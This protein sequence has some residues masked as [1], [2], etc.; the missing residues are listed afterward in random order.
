MKLL[1]GALL[2]AARADVYMQYPP[3]SNNRLAEGGGNRNNNNRLMDTQNNAKGGYGYGGNANNP[4]DP[5]NYMAGS[6]MSMGWTSQHSCGSENAE[7]Q[8]VVQYMCSPTT[9]ATTPEGLPGAGVNTGTGEGPIRDGTNGNTPD[10]NNP[11]ATRGLHEPTSFYQAC[12]NRERNKGLYTADQ[13]LNGNDARRTRQNP[14]GARS[15]LECPEERDYYPYW[16]PTPWKDAMILTNNLALCQWYKDNSQNVKAR[17]YCANPTGNGDVP[18]NPTG[19][20]AAQG[21]WTEVPAFGL[22]P[23]ECV[24]APFQRD[25]HLG[26]G[27]TGNE[28]MANLT[29]PFNAGGNGIDDAQSCVYRLRYNITTADTRVCEDPT[30][31]TKAACEAA[32]KIWSAMYLDSSFN[33]K[34]LDDTPPLPPGNPRVNLGGTL[35]NGGGTD[36]LLEL[37]INTN[38]YGRTFQDRTHVFSIQSRPEALPDN[39]NIVNLNVKG[40]RGNIVQTYPATEYDYH[41]VDLVVGASDYVHIQ[42]TGNDN[43]NNNG[44]NNGEGTNNED[45]HNIVQIADSGMDVPLPASQASMFDVQ[46]EWN[47]EPTTDANFGGPR[48]Q[49]ALT[50][51]FALSK[52]TGCDAGNQNNDQARDNCEKLN[53]A[54]ATVDLGLIKFKPG[55]FTYMSSRNNNFSNRAQKAHLKVLAAPTAP[56]EAPVN[57]QAVP[58]LSENKDVA[59]MQLTWAEPGARSAFV[60]TDGREY[61]N[62]GQA[63]SKPAAYRVQYTIDGGATWAP[64]ENCQTTQTSCTVDFLPPGTPVGFRVHSGNEAGWGEPSEVVLAKT[65]DS[66]TSLSCQQQLL[67]QMNGSYLSPGSVVAIVLGVIAALFALAFLVFMVRRRQPPPP[68]PPGMMK[69]MAP[70]GGGYA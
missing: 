56:V 53:S 11:S 3:G 41:P 30:L 15:G 1:L 59:R 68:P 7:C 22:A 21:T 43:T 6:K 26:N 14:N 42:W 55:N 57:V 54:K 63:A 27:P 25:N 69:E 23:P 52:Q 16:A 9:A 31:T 37:A 2:G 32:G 50:K 38:Q 8:I 39:A 29:I 19:C 47:P 46:W 5:I 40:K 12:D 13:N 35:T 49:L 45:R 60:G 4:A 64:V 62:V 17:G 67:D 24:A 70:P 36:S 10:P 18:N 61:W 51:Q 33:D 66:D 48:D 44:N 28:V 65:T 34:T 20:A 58:L